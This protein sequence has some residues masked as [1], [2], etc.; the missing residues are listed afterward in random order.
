MKYDLEI[1]KKEIADSKADNKEE[2]EI[3][4]LKYISK[5][6]IISELMNILKNSSNED[7][8]NI[9]QKINEIKHLA[10]Q[11]LLELSQY[12]EI[13]TISDIKEDLT[14]PPLEK[15]GS[16]HPLS[17]VTNSLIQI[18]QKIGF[19]LSDGPE[20]E[21]DWHNF[22]A[23]NIPPNHPAR[24]MQDTFFIDKDFVLRTQTSSIQIRKMENTTPP[25]RTISVG[26]VYRNEAIS[27]RS[28]CIF[29]QIEALYINKKVS[30]KDL[31]QTIYYFAKELFGKNV[32][33]RLRP[34]YFPFTEPSAEVDIS[35]I[36]CNQKGCKI[37]K[38]TGWVEIGG[39]GMIDPNVLD[40]CKIDKKIYSGFAF[41]MGI[42]RITML[43]YKINDLRLFTE[44]NIKFIR[45]FKKLNI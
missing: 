25:I 26:R 21:D 35:C 9:G 15:L 28:N 8:K 11:K 4:R 23:L 18:F 6:G 43:K 24:A 32:K 14:L 42:E 45:Q 27:A 16:K 5:K 36:I 33:I 39:T 40:N 12:L 10:K 17:I 31:K 13:S 22:T 20:I 1:I 19:N 3:Y 34:S 7:K 2:L 41:G 38:Y 44:N 30:F 37:C 29:H